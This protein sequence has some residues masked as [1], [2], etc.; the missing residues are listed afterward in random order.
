MKSLIAAL[1]IICF[2]ALMS[3]QNADTTVNNKKFKKYEVV[4][5][6]GWFSIARK[7][8]VTYTELRVANKND[9]KL[10]PGQIILIPLERPDPDDPFFDK[11]YIDKK[12]KAGKE[13]KEI[14][15]TTKKSETLYSIAKKYDVS[16]AA[17][18]EWNDLKSDTLHPGQKIIIRKNE[19][20]GKYVMDPVKPEK[21][22]TE[23]KPELV[24]DT[25]NN[26]GKEEKQIKPVNSIDR[27]PVM[28]PKIQLPDSNSNKSGNAVKAPAKKDEKKEIFANGKKEV[29]ET[30]VA[31]WIEDEDINPNKYYA[32]HK[33]APVGTIIK[34][35]NRM[36]SR[37]LFVKVIGKL[38]S[39]G[40][41]EGIIIK[42][43]KA[44]AEKLG[45]LDQHF[46][47]QLLY[48]IA[49]K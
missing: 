25:L 45:V 15:H 30:G 41:N 38:P 11:N 7:F 5:G 44:S 4:Q 32:L 36:N 37:A 47:V 9:D 46:Q 1:V 33:S 31:A 39:T 17:I 23:L 22:K 13:A 21:E 40:D 28:A 10:Q 12:G 14:V 20:T 16:V 2:P 3:A 34:I 18:K 19:S 42:I 43:S 6:D 48:G 24:R 8:N 35:T 26:S 27:S 29:S 49:E